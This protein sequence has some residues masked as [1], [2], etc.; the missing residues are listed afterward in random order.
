MVITLGQPL[1]I[2]KDLLGLVVHG[3]ETQLYDMQFVPGQYAVQPKP[4]D[5]KPHPKAGGDGT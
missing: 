4:Y 2:N 3:S 1:F 5:Y